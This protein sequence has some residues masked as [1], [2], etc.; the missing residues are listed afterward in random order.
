MGQQLRGERFTREQPCQLRG[1]RLQ[2]RHPFCLP[3]AKKWQLSP[4]KKLYTVLRCWVNAAVPAFVSPTEVRVESTPEATGPFEKIPLSRRGCSN[5]SDH[6]LLG[7]EDTF[8]A[9][10]VDEANAPSRPEGY[11]MMLP[12][13]PLTSCAPALTLKYPHPDTCFRYVHTIHSHTHR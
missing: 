4:Y 2:G 10:I 1:F 9:L 8:T 13:S 12:P 11:F 3:A 6:V 5:L 7:V